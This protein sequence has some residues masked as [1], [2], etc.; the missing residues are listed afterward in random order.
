VDS[1][2]NRRLIGASAI[3][4]P[5]KQVIDVDV[6]GLLRR[7]LLFDKYILASV[8]LQEFPILT[9]YLGYEGLRDL[10]NAKLIEIRCECLQLAQ[11]AQ[12]GLFGDKVLPLFH[13]RFHVIDARDRREYVHGCLQSLHSAAN[14]RGK[15]VVKLKGAVAAAIRR[16]PDDLRTRLFAPFH[17]ELVHN[18]N[19][20]CKSIE[21]ALHEQLGLTKVPFT[22]TVHEE[23]CDTV[24]VE[25]D[26]PGR[27]KI[28]E[29]EA[30]KI[31]ERGMMGVAGLSQTILEMQDYSAISGFRDEDMPLFRDKLSLL[32]EAASSEGHERD[33]QRVL[34][35][36]GLP[37][38]DADTGPIR[39]ERLLAIRESSEA[40]EFRD[41]LGTVGQATDSEIRERIASLRAKAGVKVGSTAGK[42][43]RFLAI[44]G[45]G[46]VPHAAVP[47]IA[48]GAL[49]QFVLER[50]LPRSGVAAFV[51]ELYPS[52]FSARRD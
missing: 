50:L 44:T 17:Y 30:H 11:I 2:I 41:W 31:I 48:L 46:L 32:A 20:L 43:M 16:P 38:V 25:T 13:Y 37:D 28:S 24:R 45:I 15:Q 33:F 5:E 40:Q 35:I 6:S 10:L 4:S 8:R 26:L 52:I 7:L 14:L 42:A 27:A 36:A 47:A 51:N 12:S 1:R 19:L 23:A 34:D 39:V 3:F 18:P 49:D 22:I 29:P 9:K 21:H